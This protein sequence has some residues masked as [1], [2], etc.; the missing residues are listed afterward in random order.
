MPTMG[1]EAVERI[2][3]DHDHMLQL[4]DRIRAECTERG[5]I[6]N[7]GD[8]SQS[9]QGVCHGNIEQMIRAFVETTLKHNLIEL[10]FMEDRVPPAHRLAH[11]QAHM[12][13][14]QQL[15]AIRVVFSE[16]GNCI[17]AIEGIDHVHQTLLTHFKE[18]DLQLEAY[19]IEATLAPQP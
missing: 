6:D 7:C 3:R 8:C 5:R 16:D 12:D 11:N 19:L 14:A 18:F 2:R 13:I 10:M 15:K 4:I 9:R 1:E 17:L